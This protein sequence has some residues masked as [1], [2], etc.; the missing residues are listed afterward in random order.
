MF[1]EFI[2]AVLVKEV[3]FGVDHVLQTGEEEQADQIHID[4][5]PYLSQFLCLFEQRTHH[6]PDHIAFEFVVVL[7]GLG[8]IS[9]QAVQK[10]GVDLL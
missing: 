3:G 6:V 9:V 1:Q 4:L 7:K 10:G 8:I 2:Q 5:G